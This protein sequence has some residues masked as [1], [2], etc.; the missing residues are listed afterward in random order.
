[1][2]PM[3]Y[4]Q[5]TIMQLNIFAASPSKLMVELYYPL[6]KMVE[7]SRNLYMHRSL[8]RHQRSLLFLLSWLHQ[9]SI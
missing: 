9:H 6:D 2:L 4:R 3:M 1:M 5:E 7:C 8:K